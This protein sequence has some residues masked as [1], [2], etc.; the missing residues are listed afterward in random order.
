MLLALVDELCADSPTVLVVDDLQWAD[1]ASLTVWNRLTLAVSQLPLLLI[2]TC[3]ALPL[4]PEVQ[5]LR[6]TVRRGGTVISLGPLNE[7]EVDELVTRRVG[8]APHGPMVALVASAMGNPL[9]LSELIVALGPER[10]LAVD[11]RNPA[12]SPDAVTAIPPSFAAVLLDRLSFMPAATMEMLRTATLLGREFADHR[13]GFA[14]ASAG[15]R[16]GGRTAG[17]AGRRDLGRR[18]LTHGIPSSVGSSGPL[19]QRARGVA[20][21]ARAWTRHRRWPPP[22]RTRWWWRGNSL[23]SVGQALAGPVGG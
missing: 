4:R 11:S 14:P 17:G 1:E 15:I 18:Q 16:V 8:F 6:A 7:A 5:E 3:H 9:Y 19:R 13:S 12:A 2:G 10:T 22:T 21:R 23:P 20:C